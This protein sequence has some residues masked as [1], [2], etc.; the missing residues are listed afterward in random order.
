MADE[1]YRKV[2]RPV[3][4]ETHYDEFPQ[5]ENGIGM[6][7]WFTNRMGR[8]RSLFPDAEANGIHKVTLVTGKLFQPILEPMVRKKLAKTQESVEVQIVGVENDFFGRSI[9]VAGL[10]VGRDIVRALES[11]PDLGQRIY[12][13]PPTL[14][15]DDLFLDD[16]PLE[17]IEERFGVP[18]QVGFRD[19]LW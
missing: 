16:M 8:V 3:P 11:V 17:A 18:V 13:P 7:R 5:I 9:S 19:R 14:N 4:P 2:G 10:L 6:T 15:D 1:W 12:L